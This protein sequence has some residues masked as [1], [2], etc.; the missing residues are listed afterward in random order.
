MNHKKIDV[1]NDALATNVLLSIEETIDSVGDCKT[2]K[3]YR[4]K[5]TSNSAKN[6]KNPTDVALNNALSARNIWG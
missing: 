4:R 6:S 5:G 3:N 2:D 1:D